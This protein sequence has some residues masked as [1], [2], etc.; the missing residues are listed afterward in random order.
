MERGGG[1]GGEERR[2]AEGYSVVRSAEHRA[3]FK[4]LL[5][6][7]KND[8]SKGRSGRRES[9]TDCVRTKENGQLK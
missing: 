8:R 3:M 6:K 1:S 5:L 2:G 9:V 4:N 7:E